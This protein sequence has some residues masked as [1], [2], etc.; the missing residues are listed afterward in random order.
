[1]PVFGKY[2]DY[3]DIFYRQKD[4]ARECDFLGKIF[5]KYSAK[6]VKSILDIG[7]GTGSHALI[8]GK[9]GY[10]VAGIDLSE[11]MIAA[12]AKKAED[13]NISVDFRQGDAKNI[14]LGRR[15]S[16]VI[17]MFAVVSYLVTND[18]LISCFK[19]VRNH[20]PK[21][22]LFVFDVWFGPAV[23]TQ[24][25]ARRFSIFDNAGEKII[26]LAS[27][28][29]DILEQT[30]KVRYNVLRISTNMVLDE[31][32]EIHK[33]RYLFPQEINNYLKEADF[34]M[35]EICPLGEL[36]KVANEAT[37]DATIIARAR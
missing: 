18:G 15:F 3:Y 20:L 36:G 19:S 32:D 34:E 26:R 31:V 16:A 13:G 29:S 35:L 10:A 11:K 28:E 22:G 2:A 9:R 1:M 25:P 33:M 24:K 30:V 4:Y 12:A 23:L 6:P 14:D 8:L 27:P 5:K 7:C 37:W 21:Q 17:S